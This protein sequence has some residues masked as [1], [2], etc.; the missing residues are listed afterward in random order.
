MLRTGRPRSWEGI[1]KGLSV[2]QKV[3]E[4][5]RLRTIAL[6]E[7]VGAPKIAAA[8]QATGK[9]LSRT[10]PTRIIEQMRDT[11]AGRLAEMDAA[12]ID[13]QVLS[14]IGVG[15]DKLD[16]ATGEA[17]AR[18]N[19]ETLAEIVR[20]HPDRFAA[21]ALLAMQDPDGAAAELTRCVMKLYW[22]V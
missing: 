5:K 13:V 7:H 2:M 22:N 6:E 1:P 8:A 10:T 4:K 12:G 21:F 15:L 3:M 17:L 19:N 9:V 20:S 14:A 18:D 11:G 16:P